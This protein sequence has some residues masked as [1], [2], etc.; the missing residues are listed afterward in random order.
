MPG[1]GVSHLSDVDRKLEKLAEEE[2]GA[3]LMTDFPEQFCNSSR[4]SGERQSGLAS[5]VIVIV[6][7]WLAVAAASVYGE[8]VWH[9]TY[10][11]P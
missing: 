3:R 11:S 7:S 2:L 9:L 1:D 6:V 10:P 8:V 5:T 4:T